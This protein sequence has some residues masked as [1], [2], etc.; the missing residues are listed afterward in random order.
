MEFSP[1]TRL[2]RS[3]FALPL[4]AMVA[5]FVVVINETGYG[6]ATATVLR[7]REQQQNRVELQFLLRSLVDAES[8]QR[9][10]LLTARPIYLE[11]YAAAVQAIDDSV[12][13]LRKA[14]ANDDDAL[15]RLKF[16]E[17]T[18]QTKVSELKTTLELHDAGKHQQWRELMLAG[19]GRETM[20]QLR[21]E[22]VTL[23]DEEERRLIAQRVRLADTLALSRLGVNV[24][25]ALAL[26]ALF[27]FLRKTR[28]LDEAQAQHALALTA[29]RN[30][31]ETEVEHRTAELTELAQHLQTAREDER[32][33]LARELHDELGALLTAAK[34]EAARLKRS[35]GATEPTVAERL[36][37]LNRT[38]DSGISLKR[39]IIENLRPSALS[40]LGLV[41]AL[42]ILAREHAERAE[43]KVYTELDAGVTLSDV[44]QITAYRLVQESLTNC[45]RYA[46]A[47]VVTITLDTV[48]AQANVAV[49]DN[50]IG[51][52]PRAVQRSSHGLT[53]MRYRVQAAG[54]RMAITSALGQGTRIEVWLPLQAHTE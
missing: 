50:G 27:L 53:G 46:K 43:I 37:S 31:L 25:A 54:G 7:L 35:L 28:A 40:N 16:I 52:D 30:Q 2:R 32:S 33:R 23:R 6:Q 21:T 8:S 20:V 45:A 29:E 19:I 42:E 1:F 18:A 39:Q 44:G 17:S 10:Y 47:T 3:P 14:F 22:V 4:A 36:A 34:L 38:L 5:L 51:F 12:A 49:Q 48:D 24:M 13:R 9:G 26:V 41:P 15:Q 11:P